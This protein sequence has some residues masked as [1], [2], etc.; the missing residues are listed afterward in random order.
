VSPPQKRDSDGELKASPHLTK[1]LMDKDEIAK[2]N[3]KLD[4]PRHW[5]EGG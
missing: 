1:V 4:E 5:S 3:R 2:L